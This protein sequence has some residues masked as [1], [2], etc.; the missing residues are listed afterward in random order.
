MTRGKLTAAAAC[1][2]DKLADILIINWSIYCELEGLF[3]MHAYVS[4]SYFIFPLWV[5]VQRQP[6]VP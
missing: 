1:R 4:Y 6:I 5:N 2:V 3:E